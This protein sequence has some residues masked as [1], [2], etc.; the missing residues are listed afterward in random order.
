MTLGMER[1]QEQKKTRRRGGKNP[2][3]SLHRQTLSGI[4]HLVTG[5]CSGRSTGAALRDCAYHIEEGGK[6]RKNMNKQ[7]KKKNKKK[8]NKKKKKNKKKINTFCS[9]IGIWS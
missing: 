6:K 1:R 9:Q 4:F 2:L 5:V 3:S 8:N 7:K